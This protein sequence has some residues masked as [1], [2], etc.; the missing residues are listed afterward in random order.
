MKTIKVNIS[1]DSIALD[2][3]KKLNGQI[4]GST[5]NTPEF[6]ILFDQVT[7]CIEDFS[8]KAKQLAKHGTTIHIVKEFTFPDTNILITLEYPREFGFMDKLKTIFK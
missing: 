3:I 8:K 1:D 6:N 5:K 7:T 2:V 4:P